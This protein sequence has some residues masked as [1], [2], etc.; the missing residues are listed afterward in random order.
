MTTLAAS[1]HCGAVTI[2]TNKDS[3]KGIVKCYC[4]DCQKHLGNYAPWVVCSKEETSFNGPVGEYT[5]SEVA[6]RLYCKECG[7]SL[8]KMPNSGE[9]TLVAAGCFE[10]PLHLEVIKEVFTE[11]KEP[12]M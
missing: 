2:T 3:V 12:W 8:A 4:R 9:V 6:K 1:C 11:A 5:S 7:S 10:Q